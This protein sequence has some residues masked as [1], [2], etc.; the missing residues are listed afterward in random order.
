[1]TTPP[2]PLQVG[3]TRGV[4][5]ISLSWTAPRE[6]DRQLVMV[7]AASGTFRLMFYTP[8]GV[9]RWGTTVP[10]DDDVQVGSVVAPG[11]TQVG[12]TI[13]AKAQGSGV[14]RIGGPTDPSIVGSLWQTATIPWNATAATVETKLS[15]LPNIGSGQVNCTGGPLDVEDVDVEFIGDYAGLDMDPLVMNSSGLAGILPTTGIDADSAGSV[16]PMTPEIGWFEAQAWIGD[17]TSGGDL[18]REAL[19]VQG[20]RWNLATALKKDKFWLRVRSVSPEGDKS[21]WV[22]HNNSTSAPATGL[23]GAARKVL[24]GLADGDPDVALFRDPDEAALRTVTADGDPADMLFGGAT[25]PGTYGRLD[26]NDTIW[27]PVRTIHPVAT[28]GV[29][30]LYIYDDGAGNVELWYRSPNGDRHKLAG[31]IL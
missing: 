25:T 3:Y 1:M 17:P 15:D 26:N 2:I 29:A 12:T 21:S 6:N 22:Y 5:G 28:A 31:T 13:T 14:T 16:K 7:N 19:H 8:V 30:K 4:H 24:F 10:E 9:S 20:N 27:I 23:H 11:F 18:F